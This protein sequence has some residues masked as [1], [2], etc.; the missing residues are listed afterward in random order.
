MAN[1]NIPTPIPLIS[2]H[3]FDVGVINIWSLFEF[4]Q[5]NKLR[6]IFVKKKVL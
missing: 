3:P 1:F 2:P 6:D 5:Q 4:Q